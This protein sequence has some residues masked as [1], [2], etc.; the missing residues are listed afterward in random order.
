MN[1][2][3]QIDLALKEVEKSLELLYDFLTCE[4]SGTD[5]TGMLGEEGETGP[6]GPKNTTAS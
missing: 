6:E 3:E 5:C 4:P 1:S 2:K